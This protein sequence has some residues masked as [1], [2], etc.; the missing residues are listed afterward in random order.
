MSNKHVRVVAPFPL[1]PKLLNQV[2]LAFALN[3]VWEQL[4]FWVSTWNPDLAFSLKVEAIPKIGTPPESLLD[5][6]KEEYPQLQVAL[7]WWM[8]QA[9][10][11]HRGDAGPQC[12]GALTVART[13]TLIFMR[14]YPATS[15]E[16][17]SCWY[18]NWRREVQN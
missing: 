4:H 8:H 2:G 17:P 13:G 18:G 7:L 1:P 11:Q 12:M 9:S 16:A 15:P 5:S 10:N 3:P 6:Y 14:Y